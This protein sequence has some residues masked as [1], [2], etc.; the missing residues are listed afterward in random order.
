MIEPVQSPYPRG[1]DSPKLNNSFS[2]LPAGLKL[3]VTAFEVGLIF[4]SALAVLAALQMAVFIQGGAS[5]ISGPEGTW[6]RAGVLV[7]IVVAARIRGAKWGAPGALILSAAIIL[8]IVTHLGTLHQS[9][10]DLDFR[11]IVVLRNLPILLISFGAFLGYLRLILD[12]HN[13]E[14]NKAESAEDGY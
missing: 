5:V 11:Q 1:S 3:C 9:T 12:W 13:G 2:Q 10:P 8:G 7:L 6:A 4:F 14:S